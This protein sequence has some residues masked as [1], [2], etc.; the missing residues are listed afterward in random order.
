[1]SASENKRSLIVGLF[2][3]IGLIILVAGILVM[4]TQQNK[5]SKN[6]KVTSYF[7]DVKGLKV[8]NNVWFSGVKV[9]IVKE[10][11]FESVE[12]VRVTMN[13]EEKKQPV[14]T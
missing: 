8:G 4:G 1:M 5:F 7:K 13:I 12:N 6:I 9:G 11:A 3:F 14:Y 2:V 10:I